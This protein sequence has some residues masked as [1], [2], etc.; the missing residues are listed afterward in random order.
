MPVKHIKHGEQMFFI[1]GEDFN[2]IKNFKWHLNKRKY[3]LTSTYINRN[4]SCLFLHRL[5]TDCPAGMFVDHIDGNPLNNCKSNL[6][7]C[8]HAENLRNQ[9]NKDNFTSKYKGVCFSKR[10]K[11]W[12]ASIMINYKHIHLGFHKNEIDAAKA[13]NKAALENFG[14]YARLNIISDL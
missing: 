14:K 6:R 9:K 7:L 1:D 13:Y 12:R 5:L 2:K 8:T 11:K 4:R 10:D 3:V